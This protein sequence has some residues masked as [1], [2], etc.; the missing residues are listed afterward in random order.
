MKSKLI[1]CFLAAALCFA[2]VPAA[3]I[4]A[5]TNL[6]AN[7]TGI[8]D[9]D[10]CELRKHSG[11]ASGAAVT[12]NTVTF[13]GELL[14][15]PVIMSIEPDKSGY[16]FHT[17]FEDGLDSWESRGSASV[18][19][20]SG[21]AAAG[22]KSALVSSRSDSWNG[23][24]R[25]L[26]SNPF[27]PGNAYSFS[28]MAMYKTGGASETFKLTL[29]Y[30][31]ADGTDHYDE[32]A[33]TE[34]SSGEWVQLAN[35]AFAIPAGA[36]NMILYIETVDSTVDFYADQLIGAAEGT[37]IKGDIY[38]AGD[39]NYS[40]KT[41]IDD[42]KDLSTLLL[43][44]IAA[45]YPDTADLDADSRI[46][47]SDLAVLKRMLI[48]PKPPVE[49][50]PL[51]EGQWDN[52]A[53]ISWIDPSKPM[54]A[55]TFDDGPVGTA[56][57][58]TSI[59]I[60]DALAANNAHAT[61]FYWG[62]KINGSNQQEIIR[63]Q[64]LGFEIGNHTYTHPYLT[65]L[66]ADA[67]KDEIGKTAAILTSLTGLESFLMRPPYLAV[68]ATVQQ[69]AGVPLV[70]CSVDPQDWNN[71]SAQ[72]IINTIT[73]KM[74]DGSLRNSI[75]LLHETYSTTAEA[76]EYLAPYMK[77]QGWQIVTVSELFKANGKDMWAGTLYNS[78]K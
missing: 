53:D 42:I 30:T 18:A 48:T 74:Q 60:Q 35:T 28:A 31:D 41:D 47:A 5:V 49:P 75:V 63:A 67:I 72:Q 38:P 62:N 54:V 8:E 13:G 70:N 12:K 58:A 32:I 37:V 26:D 24:A 21:N 61:F 78:C 22:S 45:V 66:S 29:Q 59:R 57:T 56:S 16:Y 40:S 69:N 73:A 17:T 14:G 23:I 2:G 46:S 76:V 20:V 52:K 9:G 64:S 68:N 33:S 43:G 51:A 1:S 39:V 25:A 7:A 10:D 44:K 27:A 77:Q 15:E 34:A 6:A 50:P 71:A 11:T 3:E 65:N 36:R 4:N 55:F 19:I